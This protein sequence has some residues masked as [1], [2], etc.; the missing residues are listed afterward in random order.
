M[1]AQLAI[2]TRL[3]PVEA[4]R[5][6]RRLGQNPE[7]TTQ[8]FAIFRALRGGSGVKAFKRFAGSPVGAGILRRRPSLLAS[9]SDRAA[10]AQLPG[11]SLG[12]AYLA[13]MEEENLTA[14][15]LVEASRASD[16]DTDMVPPEM[17]F[18][19]QRMRDAHDLTH[20]LTGYG[21]DPLGELCLLTFMYAHTRNLGM[22]FIVMMS[23]TR[24]PKAARAAVQEAWRNGKRARWFQNLDFEALLPRNR[25]EIR[26]ELGIITPALYRAASR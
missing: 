21:R 26:A 4:L 7:D 6:F 17:D 16:W 24:L 5:A 13:F 10:L 9:L 11:G 3:H 25:E 12:R 19:R 8:I 2:D 22:L 23:W 15:G 1:S 14:D 20:M 18:F